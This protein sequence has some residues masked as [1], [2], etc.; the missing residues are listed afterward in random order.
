M[1]V[2]DQLLGAMEYIL[3]SNIMHRDLKPANIV[4]GDGN[5]KLL[6]FGFAAVF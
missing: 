4:Y 1:A 6:D 2:F 5:V 3:G